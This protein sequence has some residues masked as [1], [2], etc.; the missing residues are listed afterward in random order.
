M[1]HIRKDSAW[2]FDTSAGGSGG[3]GDLVAS[4][5]MFVLKD[6]KGNLQRFNYG[7]AG[8]G[9]STSISGLLHKPELALPK[10]TLHGHEL[11]LTGATV[12]FP[13]SG[14]V[15]VTEGCRGPDLTI[16]QLEGPTV[17]Y[18][19]A[20]GWLRGYSWTMMILGVNQELM[21][22]G[23]ML[24]PAWEMAMALAPAVIFMQGQN[25]GLQQGGGF[26]GMLGEVHYAGPYSDR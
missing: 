3:L 19:L 10:I 9:F 12:D 22:V 24:W 16:E 18:D 26:D 7:G 21:E 11:S 6:P 14:T 1:I 4:K 20:V 23:V 5:G 15:Y 17:Y 25:E 8:L 13:S 2:T